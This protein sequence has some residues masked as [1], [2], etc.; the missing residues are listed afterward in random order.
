MARICL[1][2]F[3]TGRVQGVWFRGSTRKQAGARQVNGWARNLQDGRV[4]VMLCG[5]E[6]AVREVEAW[7]HKGPPAARV[8]QVETELVDWQEFDGFTTG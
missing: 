3:V 8:D 6:S 7:L 4:E 5:E 2:G 1:H